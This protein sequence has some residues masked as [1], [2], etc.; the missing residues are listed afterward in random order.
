MVK[1]ELE[2]LKEL[3]QIDSKIL[4]KKHFT[5]KIPSR[6]SKAELPLRE[7]QAALDKIK[8][9]QDTL[10]KSKRDKEREIDVINEKINKLKSRIADIKTNKEY[11][12]HLKEIESVEKDRYSLEDGILI[13]MEETDA[14]LKEIESQNAKLRT[15]KN[16]TDEFKK[17]LEIEMSEAEKELQSLNEKRDRIVNAIDKEIYNQYMILIES[18]NALA[19]TEA[20]GE[21]CLGCNMNIPPQ[22]FVEI[23]KNEEIINCP[24]CRRILYFKN[25]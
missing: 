15:D 20:K 1:E 16:K 13:I 4:E 24:Q 18:C 25:T 11:Q 17:K 5:D 12:A 19:V 7:S 22:L 21:I 23:K 9:K 3:Q 14:A 10:E 8:H 2:H 6:I